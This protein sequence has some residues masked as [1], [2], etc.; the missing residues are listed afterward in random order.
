VRVV[1]TRIEQ[2][3]TMQRRVVDTAQCDDR[4]HWERLAA[5]AL[6]FPQPYRPVPGIPL[7]HVSIDDQ[8]ILVAEHDLGGP[9]LNLVTAVMALGQEVLARDDLGAEVSLVPVEGA[10]RRSLYE[11]L[12][13]AL[14]PGVCQVG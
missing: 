14:A 4:L 12:R 8:V 5:R 10:A 3:G 7:Y 2:D 13:R 6:E 1:V 11:Q 9:L